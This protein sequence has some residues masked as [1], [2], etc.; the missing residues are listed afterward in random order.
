M[1]M[2]KQ[3]VRRYLAS[4]TNP[5]HLQLPQVYAQYLKGICL[6]A[7]TASGAINQDQ[8]ILKAAYI[9]TQF[10]SEMWKQI[11]APTCTQACKQSVLQGH[12]ELY[13][14]M[15]L[16]HQAINYYSTVGKNKTKQQTRALEANYL[17]LYCNSSLC[18]CITF[19]QVPF[20]PEFIC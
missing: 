11:I 5:E 17:G 4:V 10:M 15:V 13:Q 19:D 18:Q 14:Q 12:V 3:E 16:L 20:L 2:P 9:F 7:H 6:P 1:C 8:P